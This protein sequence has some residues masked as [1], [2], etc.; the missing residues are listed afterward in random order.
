MRTDLKEAVNW[1]SLLVFCLS[2]TA[3]LTFILSFTL[4]ALAIWQFDLTKFGLSWGQLFHNYRELM[5]YLNFPW[6]PTLSLSNFPVSTSGAQHFADVKIL[7]EL[8][9]GLLIISAPL[10]I[11]FWRQLKQSKQRARLYYPSQIAA[12]VPLVILGLAAIDFDQFFVTFHHLFFQNNNWLF[13]PATDP[14]IL[15]LPESFFAYCFGLAFLIFEGLMMVG[16]IY[17]RRAVKL[18]RT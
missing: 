13:D 17:G 16:L 9:W 14:I 7:F 3:V 5:A 2:L 4:F 6:V 1:L 15:V 12:V 18:K 11:R 8:A 10:A